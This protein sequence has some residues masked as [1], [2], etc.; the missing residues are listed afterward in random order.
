MCTVYRG[1][2]NALCIA[3]VYS[4]AEIIMAQDYNIIGLCTLYGVI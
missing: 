1:G 2:A 4:Y 3:G